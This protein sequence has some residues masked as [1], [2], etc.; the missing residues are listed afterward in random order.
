MRDFNIEYT[1][2][3]KPYNTSDTKRFEVEKMFDT[4][5]HKYDFLNHFLSLG[6]DVWWRKQA[7]RMIAH[8][9]PKYILDV[10]TGTGDVAIALMQLNPEKIIGIDISNNMLEIG[11]KKIIEKKIE[12]KIELRN[13]DCENLSFSNEM[14]DAIT[15]AFGVRNFENLEKGL[16]EMHR[17]LKKGKTVMILEF[18]KPTIFPFK[19]LYNFYFSFILP[20]I[21]KYF[22]KDNSAY[23][24]LP[25]SVKNFASGKEFVEILNK[26]GFKNVIT[27]QL[28]FGICTVYVAEK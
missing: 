22:S 25:E 13:E 26:I 15:V 23:S 14:F 21:G 4:I 10:A 12:N 20:F 17:V 6:I 27:K 5:A 19:Q 28:T 18:S 16:Q 9:K 8:K 3:V 24:Y 7:L 11:R 2:Q 1:L